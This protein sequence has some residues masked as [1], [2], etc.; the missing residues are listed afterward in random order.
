MFFLFSQRK[1][2]NPNF[3][4]Q[5]L[6]CR[7][8]RNSTD[9]IDAKEDIVPDN[10]LKKIYS[11]IETCSET[12]GLETESDLDVPPR[13]RKSRASMSIDDAGNDDGNDN[14]GTEKGTYSFKG[15]G[16]GRGRGKNRDKRPSQFDLHSPG[17]H[18]AS[19]HGR[20][21]VESRLPIKVVSITDVD[22]SIIKVVSIT[23][24]DV[25]II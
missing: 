18:G 17:L 24:V 7:H 25:S 9:K 5:T 20:R 10:N 1:C 12:E 2:V 11:D 23:D 14:F 19:K 13:R 4:R 15:R 21:I 6:P 16:R 3:K 8:K 22:V